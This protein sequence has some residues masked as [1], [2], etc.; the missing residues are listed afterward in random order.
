MREGWKERLT[1]LDKEIQSEEQLLWGG[2]QGSL[3]TQTDLINSPK[4]QEAFKL[5]A[6]EPI[7]VAPVLRFV[8]EKMAAMALAKLQVL[9]SPDELER[10][11]NDARKVQNA[12]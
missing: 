8:Q 11:L 9:Y 2:V 6:A 1:E 10:M 12:N 7:L 5:L 4:F 3:G